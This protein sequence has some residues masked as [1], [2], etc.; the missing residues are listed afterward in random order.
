[1]NRDVDIV[2]TA[3]STNVDIL[4]L[5]SVLLLFFMSVQ[6]SLS[7]STMRI[8]KVQQFVLIAN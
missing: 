6:V 8:M 1:M 5:F 2:G 7:L 3:V 4:A